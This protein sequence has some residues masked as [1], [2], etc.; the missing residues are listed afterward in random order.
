VALFAAI[1]GC[2][3]IAKGKSTR[4]WY[5]SSFPRRGKVCRAGKE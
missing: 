1:A 4:Q 3:N 2:G 5:L